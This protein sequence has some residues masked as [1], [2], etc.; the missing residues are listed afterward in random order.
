MRGEELANSPIPGD[1]HC[2][3]LLKGAPEFYGANAKKVG[4]L[5]TIAGRHL[6]ACVV[7]RR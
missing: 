5:A 3:E 6:E 4:I 1:L 7:V 2:F